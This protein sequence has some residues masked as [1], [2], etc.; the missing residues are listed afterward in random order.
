MRCKHSRKLVSDRTAKSRLSEIRVTETQFADDVATYCQTREAL[1][2]VTSEFVRT[3][4]EWGLT[5]STQ[6]TKALVVG[7]HLAA[8]DS[9][10]LQVGGDTLLY[11]AETWAI[12]AR[13]LKRLCGFHNHCVRSMMGISKHQQW[14]EHI[15]SRQVSVAAGMEE[16]MSDILRK[17]RLKWLGHLARMEHGRLPKQLLCSENSRRR[18]PAM[19]LSGD[20]E[21]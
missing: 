13:G 7:G 15:S 4:S 17:H 8:T 16:S 9:L 1:E 21:M 5:V 19:G 6:K 20:G 10:P 14:K 12:K 3:A 11:G 2:L 18:G